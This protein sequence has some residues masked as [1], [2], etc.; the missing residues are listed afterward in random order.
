M[1]RTQYALR[2]FSNA[3][4]GRFRTEH[5]SHDSLFAYDK[6]TVNTPVLQNFLKLGKEF[7]VSSGFVVDLFIGVGTRTTFTRYTS[8]DNLRQ[9]EGSLR[10]E[11]FDPNPADR[12]NYTI[13]R[14]A[15][16]GG[17]RLGYSF[18]KNK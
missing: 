17:L 10:R 3:S 2:N 18:K 15:V 4:G 1:P 16:T 11:L 8:I 12:Y 5:Q 6:A 14:F 13:T 9:E 7:S